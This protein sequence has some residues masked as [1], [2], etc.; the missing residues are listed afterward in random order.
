MNAIGIVW[1]GRITAT[2]QS[3]TLFTCKQDRAMLE[4]NPS[5]YA[6][7]NT[8]KKAVARIL[9][10]RICD[11]YQLWHSLFCCPFLSGCVQSVNSRTQCETLD[12]LGSFC[13]EVAFLRLA[14]NFFWFRAWL[15]LAGFGFWQLHARRIWHHDCDQQ[16][17]TARGCNNDTAHNAHDTLVTVWWV[18]LSNRK[19]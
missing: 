5:G 2:N 4:S 6:G 10:Y 18:I 1:Y 17:Q 3:D 9:W 15:L 19:T 11:W 13:R 16:K 8:D 7:H 14:R 12:P